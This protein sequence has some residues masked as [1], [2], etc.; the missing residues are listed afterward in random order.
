MRHQSI[1]KF[2]IIVYFE[3]L[4]PTFKMEYACTRNIKTGKVN[5]NMWE[6]EVCR[7]QEWL[8]GK[9]QVR[10]Y[11]YLCNEIRNIL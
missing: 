1:T 10:I 4:I 3:H 8:N 7:M 5:N 11:D 6:S 9:L 2:V